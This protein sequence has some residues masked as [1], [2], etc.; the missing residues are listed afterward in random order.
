MKSAKSENNSLNLLISLVTLISVI[1]AFLRLS[2]AV[3][4]FVGSWKLIIL[5]IEV[6]SSITIISIPFCLYV[7]AF[8]WT[9]LNYLAKGKRLYETTR[10]CWLVLLYLC[11]IPFLNYYFIILTAGYK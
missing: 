9:K 8:H 11:L 6:L 2:M 4:E 7:L 1:L 10:K 5:A 3:L